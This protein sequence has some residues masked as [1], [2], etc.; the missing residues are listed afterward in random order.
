MRGEVEHRLLTTVEH[1]GLVVLDLG[2]K[3]LLALS[4]AVVLV[5]PAWGNLEGKGSV[6]RALGYPL[7]ALVVPVWWWART[8][9]AGSVRPPYPWL[10][11]ALLTGT[12]FSDILGNRLDLYDEVV[13]FDDV[14]HLVTSVAICSAVL[15]LTAARDASLRQLAERSVAVGMT[16]SLTWELLEYAAFVTRSSELRTA[17]ADTLGDL[18]LNWLGTI[19]AAALV[20]LRWRHHV[21]AP[22][23][24]SPRGS[25]ARARQGSP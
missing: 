18:T 17:Y 25:T 14:M 16:I 9:R 12:G 15:L 3:A 21:S 19:V 6:A 4:L 2:A 13:W 10:A 7:V 22:V 8:L 1:R 23:T 20:H 24:P 11:D 5:D